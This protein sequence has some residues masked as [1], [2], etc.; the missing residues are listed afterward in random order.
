MSK[1]HCVMGLD[2][3][4]LF[5]AMGFIYL[6]LIFLC[7]LDG[8]VVVT[9]CLVDEK[10]WVKEK[11]YLDLVILGLKKNL[12][13]CFS[14]FRGFDFGVYLLGAKSKIWNVLFMRFNLGNFEKLN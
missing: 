14:N 9:F 1:Q 12:K 5:L 4:F 6:F 2:L 8:G 10:M 13:C 3:D 7:G 11:S